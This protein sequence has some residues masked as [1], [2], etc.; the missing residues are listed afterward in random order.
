MYYI[1][2]GEPPNTTISFLLLHLKEHKLALISLKHQNRHVFFLRSFCTSANGLFILSSQD[3]KWLTTQLTIDWYQR[4][5]KI[6]TKE[7]SRG[8]VDTQVLKKNNESKLDI[9]KHQL[10]YAKRVLHMK[11]TNRLYCHTWQAKDT[12]SQCQLAHQAAHPAQN[13]YRSRQRLQPHALV[14]LA[15][16][17]HPS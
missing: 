3:I 11:T 5:G 6:Q 10:M 4:Q 17:C 7:P 8:I 1:C 12:Q 13:N 2:E 15:N 9:K 16:T 14:H